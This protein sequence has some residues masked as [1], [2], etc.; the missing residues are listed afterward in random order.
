[1]VRADEYAALFETGQY[2]RF[3]FVSYS[4][5]RGKTFQIFILPKGEKAISNGHSNP[6][7]NYDSVLVYGVISGNPGWTETYGWIHKG[8]W[9]SDFLE[10]VDV[11]KKEISLTIKNTKH[12]K[13]KKEITEQ[14]RIKRLL[15]AY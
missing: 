8:K 12:A 15:G 13:A 2:G 3:Y 11:R 9:Q 4:H 5:A 7:L 14:E 6:P 1:M 10:L